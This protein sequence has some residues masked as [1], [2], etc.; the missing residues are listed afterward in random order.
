[1]LLQQALQLPAS[2]ECV[3][4]CEAGGGGGGGGAWCQ[5]KASRNMT[6]LTL[7]L[8]DNDS[9]QKS[10]HT[11]QEEGGGE[12]QAICIGLQR[13]YMIPRR[14]HCCGEGSEHR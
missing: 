8:Q 11:S 14:A 5:C 6:H 10:W 12:G 4:V 13:I 2:G 9:C 1:M 7:P 3:C